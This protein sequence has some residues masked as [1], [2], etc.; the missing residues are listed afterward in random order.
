MNLLRSRA[1]LGAAA[2][3]G[4]GLIGYALF[5][6]PT[7]EE[8]IHE[9]LNELEDAVGFQSPPNPLA[10]AATVRRRLADLVSADVVVDLPERGMV[11]RG[12]D[13]VVRLA[14]AGTSRM[15][16]FDVAFSVERLDV[17]GDSATASVDVATEASVGSDPRIS[18]RRADLE[19]VKTDG[20]WRLASAHVLP[21]GDE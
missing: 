6:Q 18:S 1:V 20:D 9:V 16:R 5:S 19:F 7:D 14:V 12:R 10:H 3:L 4:L 2:F 15:Q 21:Q 11:A 8:R 13:D 17:I